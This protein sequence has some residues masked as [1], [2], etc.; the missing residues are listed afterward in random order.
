M[1]Y[2]SALKEKENPGDREEEEGRKFDQ[3]GRAPMKLWPWGEKTE[4]SFSL[5][6]HN[7]GGGGKRPRWQRKGKGGAKKGR[8]RRDTRGEN[9]SCISPRE[10]SDEGKREGRKA[11]QWGEGRRIY[12][13]E[14][15]KRRR[16]ALDLCK[17]R[18][19]GV[20]P[21]NLLSPSRR[22]GKGELSPFK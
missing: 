14:G 10:R 17:E 6:L 22:R 13:R 19:S 2:L 21:L 18:S 4:S 1:V 16:I 3:G 15:K 5:K 11:V 20:I 12:Q 8:R 7:I 9:R